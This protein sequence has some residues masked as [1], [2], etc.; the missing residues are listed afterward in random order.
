MRCN[1]AANTDESMRLDLQH[2]LSEDRQV[3]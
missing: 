3:A 2:L 1:F